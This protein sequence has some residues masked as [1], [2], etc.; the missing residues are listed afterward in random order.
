[1]L[2]A[3][4][5][6][7]RVKA[8]RFLNQCRISQSKTVGGLSERQRAELVGLFAADAARLFVVTG[9]SGA[10]K[11]TLIRGLVERRRD[12]EVAVSA[13]TRPRRPGS[14]TAA[15]TTS[16]PTRSSTRSV[17]RGDFLEHVVVRR[18]AV[19]HAERRGRS[20]PRVRPR[21][22]PRARDRRAPTRVKRSAS[23]RRDDLHRGAELRGARAAPARAG[24][25]E[26]AAR[27]ASGST[28]ARRQMEEAGDFDYVVDERRRRA[29]RRRA[30]RDRHDGSRDGAGTLARP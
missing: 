10:G 1:M 25:R 19:R 28:L 9:P 20:D 18:A 16:S 26:R 6:F 4:P 17:A 15:S 27:S 7:G 30:R 22:R 14:R 11:G 23:R 24:D 8:A 12:L 21:L 3:V 2:M 13:T 5:K 29:G